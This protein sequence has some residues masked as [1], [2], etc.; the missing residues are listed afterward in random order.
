MKVSECVTEC[1]FCP[2]K[3]NEEFETMEQALADANYDAAMERMME[4]QTKERLETE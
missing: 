2:H 3:C 1:D 4:S